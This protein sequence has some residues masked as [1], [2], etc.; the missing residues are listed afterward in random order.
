FTGLR[1][2]EKITE[3]LVDDNEVREKV[4]PGIYEV[5]NQANVPPISDAIMQTLYCLAQEGHDE[6][7]KTM[8]FNLVKSLRQAG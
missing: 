6:Q 7:A 3:A 4:L 2:G 1:E 5:V 8:V